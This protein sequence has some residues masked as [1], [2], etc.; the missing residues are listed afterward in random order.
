MQRFFYLILFFV[1]IH[2]ALSQQDTTI[3]AS[4][5]GH[6]FKPA[7]EEASQANVAQLKLP[8][9]FTIAK[10]AEGLKKPRTVPCWSPTTP[11]A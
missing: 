4:V 1:L 8:Q 3:T 10:F 7:K 5:N 2:P 9:G 11:T 6:I